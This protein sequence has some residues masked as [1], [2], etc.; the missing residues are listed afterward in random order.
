[1]R[2]PPEDPSYTLQRVWLSDEEVEEYYYGYS[3]QVLWPL[4]HGD[5]GNIT[6]DLDAWMDDIFRTV[7]DLRTEASDERVERDGN[8]G[9]SAEADG[10]NV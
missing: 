4:C 6:Y 7:E 10:R 1:V 5:V 3:N 9:Q 8:D 2:V